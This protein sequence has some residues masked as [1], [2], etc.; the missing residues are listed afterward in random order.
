MKLLKD[1]EH[2]PHKEKKGGTGHG[3]KK[4]L[5]KLLKDV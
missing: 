5:M 2:F 1:V 3:R 4:N